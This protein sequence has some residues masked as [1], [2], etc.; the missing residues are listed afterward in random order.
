MQLIVVLTLGSTG[1]A[2]RTAAA[3]TISRQSRL[4]RALL[5]GLS[6]VSNRWRSSAVH[7]LIM[8]IGGHRSLILYHI[9]DTKSNFYIPTHYI[10]D[11]LSQLHP[12]T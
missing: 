7:Q 9:S 5:W 6:V 10:I 4:C 3:Q 8:V 12:I 2:Q 11:I 1:A